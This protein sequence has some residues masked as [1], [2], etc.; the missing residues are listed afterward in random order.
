MD[1]ML[2]LVTDE[3]VVLRADAPRAVDLKA[4]GW[5]AIAHSWGA[6]LSVENVDRVT[7]LGLIERIRPTIAVR[8]IGN[9]HV[10][11]ILSL[12]AATAAD[13]PG[14]VATRHE[15]LTRHRATPSPVRR[16]T[17]AFGP[18][19]E[20]IAMTFVDIAGQRAEIDFTV[21][22][23]NWRGRGIGTAVKAASVLNLIDAGIQRI[24]TGG[25]AENPSILAANAALGFVIDEHWVTLSPP[26]R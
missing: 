6:G 9:E 18:D 19:G 24:R 7:L 11:A 5:V 16:A 1:A 23:P 4:H 26:A 3:L 8:G 12:D 14:S 20:L 17:G 10:D 21:V 15:P 13:Y 25:S 2:D 22:G